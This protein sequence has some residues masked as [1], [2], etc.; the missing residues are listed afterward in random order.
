MEL[1]AADQDDHVAFPPFDEE[2]AF[3]LVGDVA[4]VQPAVLKG[5]GGRVRMVPISFHDAGSLDEKLSM[6][7]FAHVAFLVLEGIVAAV[8][9]QEPGER[10][11]D[12]AE[13][14]VFL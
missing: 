10:P 13:K 12:G 4:R 6:D 5:F 8:F 14:M 11:A 9:R 1:F 7:V 2:V 3:L